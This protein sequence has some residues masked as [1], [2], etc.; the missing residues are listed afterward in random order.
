MPDELKRSTMTAMRLAGAARSQVDDNTAT[1][2]K[3]SG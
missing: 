2:D 3:P 1:R